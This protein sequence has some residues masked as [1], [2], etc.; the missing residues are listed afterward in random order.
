MITFL[1]FASKKN[2]NVLLKDQL[3][4]PAARWTEEAWV[5]ELFEELEQ[6]EEY[7]SQDPLLD[8]VSWDVTVRGRWN[9]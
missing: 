6:V 7:L 4:I 5:Y 8:I 2:E 1:S 9:A 3:R